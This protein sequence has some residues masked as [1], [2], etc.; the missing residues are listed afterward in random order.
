VGVWQTPDYFLLR[1]DAAGWEEWKT[2]AG[3]ERLAEIM[4][5]RYVRNE[6]GHWRCPPREPV[7]ERFG[8]YYRL[9]SSAEIDWVLQRNLRF[10]ADYLAVESPPITEQATNEILALVRQERGL[11][12]DELIPQLREARNDDVYALIAGNRV[13]VD[14]KAAPLAEPE[15]VRLFRDADIASAFLVVGMADPAARSLRASLHKQLARASPADLREANR[16]HAI[17]TPYLTGMGVVCGVTPDR[18]IREWVARWRA[19]E[20]IDGSG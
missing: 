8:L 17:I 2:E 12:L 16:R 5:Q 20:Q 13:Y 18:T 6:T 11:H 1:G 15:R 3:L 19:A 4:P 14:L 10:L 9:Y 7:A